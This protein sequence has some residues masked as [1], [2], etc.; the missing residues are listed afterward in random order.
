[1]KK[2][3][4]ETLIYSVVGIVIFLVIVIAVNVV[5]GRFKERVDLT[6]EKT[7]TLSAGTK[8]ILA[9]LTNKVTIRYYY[10]SSEGDSG[11][12]ILLKS[13]AQHVADLLDEYKQAGKGKIVVEQFDP[14]PD[15]DAEDSARLDGVEGQLLPNGEKF[16]MGISI[17]MLENKEAIPFLDP[18]REKLLE[19][20]LSRSITRVEQPEK[21]VVGIMTPLPMF[22][23]AA[24]PM[25]A[26]RGAAA[27]RPGTLG[28]RQ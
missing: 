20:D 19:Y 25:M 6:K 8:S 18:S 21:P 11:E 15:S 5:A 7:Y 10:S 27:G 28:V 17:S 13:Y 14:K 12:T 16:Y 23:Q 9:N 4:F 1:M 22:G 26:M 3:S 2:N 24:N